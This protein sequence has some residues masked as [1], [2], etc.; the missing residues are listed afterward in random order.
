MLKS[1]LA[2]LAGIIGGSAVIWL[3]EA[4]G[5]ALF[6]APAGLGMQGPGVTSEHL[7]QMPV[8]LLSVVLLAYAAGSFAG[9]WI[10]VAISEKL[11]DSIIVGFALLV[12]GIV[13]LLMVSHP[14]WF[15]VVSVLI[16]IPCAY[17]GGK[18]RVR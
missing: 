9:G 11:R 10:S 16:Y 2:V 8:L 15:V 3:I 13:N 5:H 18:I 17:W 14:V 1:S 4:L 7:Q 12:F 6:P